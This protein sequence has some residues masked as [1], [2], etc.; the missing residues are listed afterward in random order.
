MGKFAEFDRVRLGLDGTLCSRSMT[1]HVHMEKRRKRVRSGA[2]QKP[3]I[4]NI[5]GNISSL[6]HVL[7]EKASNFSDFFSLRRTKW[8]KISEDWIAQLFLTF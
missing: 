5:P 8:H 4:K 3:A 1:V 7:R 6:G 2:E